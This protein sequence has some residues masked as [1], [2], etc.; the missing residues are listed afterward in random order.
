MKSTSARGIRVVSF[1]MIVLVFCI[2]AAPAAAQ[3]PSMYDVVEIG[4]VNRT[5]DINSRGEVVGSIRGPSGPGSRAFYWFDG[6]FVDLGANWE[7]NASSAASINNSGV[8]LGTVFGNGD[9]PDRLFEIDEQGEISYPAPFTWAA[10][11]NARE[12]NDMGQI[13]GTYR[14]PPN[15]ASVLFFWDR[16]TVDDLV[17]EG[18][19]LTFFGGLN[20]MGQV[21]GS[22]RKIE[23]YLSGFLWT[24]GSFTDVGTCEGNPLVYGIN[25]SSQIVGSI[26]FEGEDQKHAFLFENGYFIDLGVL[27]EGG[28]SVANGINNHGWVVGD[29][30]V[31]TYPAIRAFV[32]VEGVM[33]DLN[34]F[35]S[36]DCPWHLT[37]ALKINDRGQILMLANLKSSVGSTYLL[38]TPQSITIEG[39]IE[40]IVS[41]DIHH[42][43]EHALVVKLEHAIEA[44][45]AGDMDAACGRLR[46]FINQ[47]NAQTGKKISET[48]AE[49]LLEGADEIRYSL[50]CP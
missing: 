24:D 50:G 29:A 31:I 11:V 4:P 43:I 37:K 19:S 26:V 2:G 9:E 8:I 13:V 33:Y 38:L 48:Q 3:E 7:A 5:P 36:E 6:V 46:A 34:D 21:A 10:D 18:A 40:L 42:G 30:S 22:A 25:D 17:P 35:V 15:G 23:C 32:S 45:D 49:E 16:N 41:F 44:I 39:L 47:V 1:A 20:N 14:L 28:T 27:H 12:I